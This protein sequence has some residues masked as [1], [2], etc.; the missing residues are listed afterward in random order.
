MASCWLVCDLRLPFPDSC[1]ADLPC[2]GLFTMKDKALSAQHGPLRILQS[3]VFYPRG[4]SAQV[5]RYLSRALMELGHE[6]HLATGTL[7]DGN[8]EHD[9]KTFYDE[10]PLTTA[11]Y[12][13]AW[14]GF[15]QGR[16]SISPNWNVPFQPSYEDKAGVPDRAFYK[17]NAE[18]YAALRHTWE[19]LF[20]GLGRHLQ[21]HVVHLH[22]LNHM[23]LAAAKLYADVPRASQLHGT[24]IKMLENLAH[25]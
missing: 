12:T 7:S 1:L 5:V 20:A 3:L 23:H 21:P 18:A 10:I 2:R 25:L 15:D 19:V 17:V 16:N 14:R 11:D 4:G 9:A 24:E 8:P 22:H 13:E 6:V